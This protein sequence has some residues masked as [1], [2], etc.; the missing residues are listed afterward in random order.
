MRVHKF[1]AGFFLT[2]AIMSA[3]VVTPAA[4]AKVSCL[5]DCPNNV[6]A[7]P[8]HAMRPA[9]HR[10]ARASGYDYAAAAPVNEY[11]WHSGWRRVPN[12]AVIDL[13]PD[14]Y[15]PSPQPY[16]P[17]PGYDDAGVQLDNGGWS[18][19]V[20]YGGEGGGGGGG[21]DFGQVHFGNGGSVENG[22]TY[23]SYN[24]SFQYNPSQ[25][26]AFQPRL[27]GGFAPP[28]SK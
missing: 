4:A 24:Q 16:G 6:K 28:S 3:G 19:G 17:P 14:G 26:G 10:I 18:G 2:A 20:G 27:M 8:H 23:N 7:R 21:G 9:P 5:C 13:P 1:M 25:P 22:P 12:D 11:G 15:I